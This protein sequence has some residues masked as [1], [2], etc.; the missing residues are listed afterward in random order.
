V[1]DTHPHDEMLLRLALDDVVEADRESTLR[2]LDACHRCRN[3][4]DALS[5]AVEQ[6]LAAAPSVEPS[7]GFD[8]RVLG[9]MGLDPAASHRVPPRRSGRRWRLAAGSVAAGL[10]IGLGGGY[11]AS[12]LT[13]PDPATTPQNTAFLETA[14]GEQVG[15]VTRTL[16]EGEPALVVTVTSGRIGMDYL[17]LLRLED[18][19]Q[20]PTADWKL[21][22]EEGETW[23]VRPHAQEVSEVVLVANGGAGPVWSTARL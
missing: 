20:I 10:I 3:E 2:H 8:A 9:A 6:T 16:L 19:E 22:S 15:M 23:V 1:T 5:A 7:P 4:Y 12:E 13:E 17:C 11:L 18:G 21:D 14:D